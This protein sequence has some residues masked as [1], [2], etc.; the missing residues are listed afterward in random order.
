MQGWIKVHRKLLNSE[1]FRNEKLLKVFMYC[2]LKASHSDFQQVIGRQAVPV[3]PGQF[4]FGRKKAA[5]ELEMHESTVR[6]YINLLKKQEIIDIKST[7]K[8]SV[9][10]VV[11]WGLYQS[12]NENPDN[13]NANKKT[14]ERQ[15]KDTYKNVK[16][17]KE[18]N[19]IAEIKDLR[20]QY[21]PE[22]QALIDQYWNAIKKTRKT[23]QISY[24]VIA[25]TMK[26]WN[27]FEK[28]IV[29]YALKKHLAAYD[30]EDHNEKYTLGIMRNTTTDQATDLLT[31]K[32]S[33]F[34]RPEPQNNL[35]QFDLDNLY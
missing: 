22:V 5:Q 27:K 20:Q 9:I 6:D 24:S 4:V 1:V 3:N 14:T 2:L 31:K 15:Q 25:K 32:E 23:N 28:V 16:N 8:Y 33:K 12:E 17:D 29:H 26:L 7:N 18:E 30:D 13:K 35:T 11:N 19:I 10:T 34:K 21:S